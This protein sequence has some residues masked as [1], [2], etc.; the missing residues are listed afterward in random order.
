[1]GNTSIFIFLFT[2]LKIFHWLDVTWVTF[3][4]IGQSDSR[5]SL[6]D[7]KCSES[8]F[9]LKILIQCSQMIGV[10]FLKFEMFLFLVVGRSDYQLAAGIQDLC[11][12][13]WQRSWAVN[14]CCF[15]EGNTIVSDDEHRQSGGFHCVLMQGV[16]P[17]A[18]AAMARPQS[19]CGGRIPGFSEQPGVG[20]DGL[21]PS[22]SQNGRH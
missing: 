5:I 14:I 10:G 19:G 7:S 18:E 13:A 17:R 3:H 12:S 8:E 16:F 22:L 2:C 11:H 20:P 1:M 6:N 15:G 21:S 4:W 9:C